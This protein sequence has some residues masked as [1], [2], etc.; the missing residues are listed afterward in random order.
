MWLCRFNPQLLSHNWVVE[1]VQ[2]LGGKV[3][4]GGETT[5]I[6]LFF[7]NTEKTDFG[8]KGFKLLWKKEKNINVTELK[9]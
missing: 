8:S 7:G 3:D 9:K 6:W 5:L 2:Q 1:L 4:K